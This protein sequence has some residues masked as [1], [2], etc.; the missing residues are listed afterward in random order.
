MQ[1][2]NYIGEHLLPGR[3]GQ[4]FLV[5]AFCSA[6]LASV[7]YYFATSRREQL[8][9]AATWKKIGRLAFI[10]K[11]FSVFMVIGIMFFMMI[12]MVLP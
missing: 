2:I 9:E 1:E 5:L 7:S 12:N 8:A 4:F 3:M 6:L 10:A 11:G